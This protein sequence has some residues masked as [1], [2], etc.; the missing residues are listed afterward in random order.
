MIR[1][2]F[3]WYSFLLKSFQP[4]QFGID[5]EEIGDSAIEI[6]QKCFHL[7]Y[8][9]FF[10]LGKIYVYRKDGAIYK[11]P[12]EYKKRVKSQ[13]KTRTPFYTYSLI[14][15]VFLGVGFDWGSYEWN[16]ARVNG[17]LE[18][19]YNYKTARQLR[20]I[21]KLDTLT[22][23]NIIASKYPDINNGLFLKVQAIEGDSVVV[24]KMRAG[25]LDEDN[26]AFSYLLRNYYL[27]NKESLESLTIARK[28]LKKAVCT[29]YD[30]LEKRKAKGVKFLN[31]GKPYIIHDIERIDSGPAI[32]IDEIFSHEKK[33][34]HFMFAN[35]GEECHLVKI[36]NLTEKIDWQEKLPMLLE[37]DD[38]TYSGHSGFMLHGENCSS[39]NF[40]FIM[41]L[42]SKRNKLYKYKVKVVNMR[43]MVYRVR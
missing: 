6:R 37:T 1:V 9:P 23:I 17:N 21:D 42:K 19:A 14:I 41:H 40:S 8:I 39:E 35:Y 22:Y 5:D 29:S 30:I 31:N 15:L 33:E 13:T 36:K 16:R 10:S 11:L 27:E 28:D 25:L 43:A 7:F 20:M 26:R 34:I 32:K 18:T 2:V 24:L 12:H 3:G 4:E 38:K